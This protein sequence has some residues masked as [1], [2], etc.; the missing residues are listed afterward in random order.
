MEAENFLLGLT[1]HLVNIRI[2][3]VKTPQLSLFWV[4][5]FKLSI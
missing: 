2:F 5:T 4:K 1:S 3:N